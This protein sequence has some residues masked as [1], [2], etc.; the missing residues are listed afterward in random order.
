M[1]S[2]Y[3]GTRFH[4]TVQSIIAFPVY[5]D[6]PQARKVPAG[7]FTCKSKRYFEK[8][9]PSLLETPYAPGEADVGYSIFPSGA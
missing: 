4:R 8:G 5:L 1:R 2:K 7:V 3:Q 9:G 6:T